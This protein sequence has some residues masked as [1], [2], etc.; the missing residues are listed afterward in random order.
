MRS[1]TSLFCLISALAVATGAIRGDEALG[2]KIIRLPELAVNE[3]MKLRPREKWLTG[4]LGSF[5]IYSTAS[6]SETKD[7]A[8]KLQKF[9]QTFALLF[10]KLIGNSG[11]KI[12]LVLCGTRDKYLALAPT[13]AGQVDERYGNLAYATLKDGFGTTFLINFDAK[14]FFGDGTSAGMNTGG[15]ENAAPTMNFSQSTGAEFVDGETLL[16]QQYLRLLLSRSQ[17]RPPAWLEEG[18]VRYFDSLKVQKDKITFAQLDMSLTRY[19]SRE[20]LNTRRMMDMKDFFAVTYDSPEY[21]KVVGGTFSHQALAF[22]HYAMLSHKGRYRATFLKFID[23]ASKE[24]VTETIFK[25]YFKMSFSDMEAVLDDYVQGGFYRHVVAP[26]PAELPPAPPL[27]LRETTDAESGRIKGDVLRQVKRYEDARLELV[28]PLMRK[29]AD[30]RL[31]ASLGLLGYE[32]N[33]L[34]AARKFL[35]E[36]IAAKVDNPIAYVTLAR[37]RLEDAQHG[38]PETKLTPAQLNGVLTPLFAALSQKLSHVEIYTLIA[39]AWLCSKTAP[40]LDNLAILDEGVLSFPRNADLIY[41]NATLKARHGFTDDAR[42]LA[43]LGLKIARDTANRNRFEQL[44][45][46]LPASQLPATKS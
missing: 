6:E 18:V 46:S 33:S 23:Q 7:F 10:P 41:K 38:S 29:Q 31:L 3:T 2:E 34:A 40:T 16:R 25:N 42:S 9:H 14:A 12:T 27:V 4:Q 21:R 37:L 13:D 19:F 43:D 11:D 5:E 44:K 36:A 24:P 45:A 17:S 32:T 30:A 20:R 8:T 28:S 26:K 35:E 22:V 1:N 39:D 15:G